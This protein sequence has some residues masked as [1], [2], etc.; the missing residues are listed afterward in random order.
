MTTSDS[1]P[2]EASYLGAIDEAYAWYRQMRESQP[3]YYDAKSNCWLIFRYDDVQ[4]V[5]LDHTTF[6]SRG[7]DPST[8]PIGASMINSDPPRHRQLRSLATQAFTFD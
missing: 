8:D 4:H 1:T 6:S 2:Q 5:L 3:V 7:D